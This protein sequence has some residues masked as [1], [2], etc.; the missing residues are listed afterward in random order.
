MTELRDLQGEAA[1]ELRLLQRLKQALP[2]ATEQA[3]AALLQLRIQPVPATQELPAPGDT[4]ASSFP[5]P[6]IDPDT[7][8]TDSDY[9]P[10]EKNLPFLYLHGI[11]AKEADMDT[12]SEPDWYAQTQAFE[13]EV[14]SDITMPKNPEPLLNWRQ[15]WP[16]IHDLFRDYKNTHQLHTPT[17][18]RHAVRREPL[19]AIPW[20]QRLRWPNELVLLVDASRHLCPY[21]SDYQLVTTHLMRWLRDRLKVVICVDGE[22]QQYV[23]NDRSYSELP[24]FIHD[25][26]VL[27]LGDLG[28]LDRQ[29]ISL[30]RWY[31]TGRTL[32]QR[33]VRVEALV[34]ADPSDWEGDLLRDYSVHGWDSG[35]VVSRQAARKHGCA[36][37]TVS[38]LQQ[39]MAHLSQALEVTPTLV[40]NMRR[41][42]GF[43]VSVE[44]LVFQHRAL[45]GNAVCFQ[46]RSKA[47]RAVFREQF[48]AQGGQHEQAWAIIQQ[49]E[50][51][52]PLELQ[53]EQR[54]QLGQALN[55][56]QRRFIHRL[57]KSQRQS[58][59]DEAQAML[60][61]WIKRMAHRAGTEAWSEETQLLYALYWQENKQRE[62]CVVPDGV[63]PTRLPEWIIGSASST[64]AIRLMQ[65]GQ[66]LVL[67]STEADHSPQGVE[68]AR[69]Q[70]SEGSGLQ[71]YS[72]QGSVKRP[73]WPDRRM[74]L[75]DDLTEL[76]IDTPVQR[77]R[78]KTI[79]CPPWA[80]GLGR[81]RYGLFAEVQVQDL[82]FIMRWIPPGEFMMGSSEDE[83]GRYDDESPQHRV[84]FTQGF[85]LAETACTQALWQRV[86]GE[87]P[88]QLKKNPQNPVENIKWT[89]AKEFITKLNQQGLAVCLP[90]E[91]EW[92]YACRAGTTTRYS[93]GDEI[94]ERQANYN[95]N[96][97][98][99]QAVKSYIPN[100]WGLYQMHSNVWEWCEDRWHDS[101]EDA[102]ADGS[103]WM[104]GDS[105]EAVCRGGSWIG[106]GRHL[107][108]AY[109][110][111]VIFVVNRGFRLARGPERQS[112]QPEDADAAVSRRNQ[113]E[114]PLHNRFYF[115]SS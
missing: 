100:K 7:H 108:S 59:S 101:Y 53:I 19:T 31:E 94:D 80:T 65:Q 52:L 28:F 115:S 10:A 51:G 96:N 93:F 46:W 21:F 43:N 45:K 24:A 95:D 49:Y 104:T 18:I 61:A 50:A 99:A 27:Y 86:M 25:T 8:Q 81:D 79:T 106:S 26:E 89:M 22:R 92:E 4:E 14:E 35:G 11:E 77:I 97:N 84:R 33:N 105:K 62:A 42:L 29:G 74:A 47:H 85:W 109:R 3:L 13:Q 41:Q 98:G 87:S 82:A 34:T 60:L 63:D 39:L 6:A 17:L 73:V 2:S 111:D 72:R 16:L 70:W 30:A 9:P 102:P 107:R 20:R 83:P 67:V 78:L 71:L 40:R 32:K 112:S 5:R 38:Q 58:L 44:S 55:E 36:R 76:V 12:G 54:Q 57:V 90:S 64:Q 103:A 110:H 48:N 91:A 113:H 75:P 37:G 88:S 1:A 69:F 68:L 114:S 15:L 23:Y 56:S 66:S